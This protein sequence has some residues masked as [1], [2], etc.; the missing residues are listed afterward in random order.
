MEI[1]KRGAGGLE[2]KGIAF[3]AIDSLGEVVS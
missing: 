1:V 3:C 2:W